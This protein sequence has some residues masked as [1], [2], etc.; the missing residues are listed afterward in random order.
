MHLKK[1]KLM[2]FFSTDT[3]AQ[4]Y[5]EDRPYLH[6][7]IIQKIK[8]HLKLT[9][10]VKEA[11]DVGCGA[12]LSTL[13]LKEIAEH[14]TGVDSSEAMIHSAV[15]DERV[16]YFLYPAEN[17]PFAQKFDLITVA[18][19][20]N[21][22][23]RGRFFAEAKKIL[24]DDGWIVIYDFYIL[25]IMEENEHF[26]SWYR[27]DYLARYPKPP[28]DE[29]PITRKEAATYGITPAGSEE[30]RTTVK[31][32][33]QSYIR[34]MLTQSNITTALKNKSEMRDQINA[35]FAAAAAPFFENG[36]KSLVFGGYVWYFN[37]KV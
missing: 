37:K 14:I 25:G 31:F 35:W 6:P 33:L 23:E 28:R 17:L 3:V 10:K 16:E 22:I 1:E 26:A 13:A 18:G 20:I 12:G 27:H 9:R 15:R 30:Y 2:S 7:E 19:A 8:N 24:R 11:L 36:K 4:G 32:S 5:A 21:W 34:F 29:S